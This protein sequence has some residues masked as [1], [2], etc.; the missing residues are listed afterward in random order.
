[1]GAK[2]LW[3]PVLS[4][5]CVACAAPV[6]ADTIV[7]LNIHTDTVWD[8]AG[9]PYIIEKQTVT[10]RFGSTLT[11]EPG[12]EV[13]FQP[14]RMLTT[15]IGCSIAAVGTSGDQIVFTSSAATPATSDWN[16]VEVYASDGSSFEHCVFRYADT[17]LHVIACEP[18]VSYCS[19]QDCEKG[20]YCQ[21]ASPTIAH[22]SFTGSTWA[23][24]HCYGRD[25]LPVIED[26][27]LWGNFWNL[28]LQFYSGLEPEVTITAEGNWWGTD[29]EA[30][31]AESIYD[32]ADNSAVNGVVDYAPWLSD[33][34]VERTSWGVIKRLFRD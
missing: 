33:Q 23:A 15:D 2:L 30:E 31:I 16:K 10:V 13:R 24:I 4:V 29:V 11:I 14:G 6:G 28:Y 25:S 5:V 27:N 17:G 19:F 20:I 1:M 3:V 34:P 32:K 9:S 21:L 22:S 8:A 26:C 12:V 7:N 18:G